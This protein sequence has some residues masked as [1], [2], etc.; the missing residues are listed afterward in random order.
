MLTKDVLKANAALSGLTD[1]QIQAI[2]QL[3]KNDEEVQIGQVTKRIHTQYD[4][5][6]K[7]V[8]G[9]SKP[10][11]V[12]SYDHL[13][14]QLNILKTK[15]DSAGNISQIQSENDQLKADKAKLEQQLQNGSSDQALKTKIQTLEQTVSDRDSEINQLKESHQNDLK[16]M[17]DKYNQ[18]ISKNTSL[19][20]GSLID[21]YSRD[22]KIQYLTT[23]PEGLRKRTFKTEK[24]LF[25]SELKTDYIDDDQG[26]QRL[27][28]RGADGEILRN[29]ENG[30]NPYTAGEL[31]FARDGIKEM[32]DHGKVQNG[33]NTKAG[34]TSQ[35]P[36]NLD[37]SSAKTQVEADK[38]ITQH[39]MTVEG[40]SKSDSKFYDRQTEIRNEAKV[41]DL[42]IREGEASS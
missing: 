2:E 11:N 19:E 8:L 23:I 13:K 22:N 33:A 5:D 42:P 32:I 30:L 20:I 7:S 26:G 35:I 34:N 25:I 4:D 14:Q 41:G 29:K 31:F 3:S 38:M 16:S 39:L 1:E 37:L 28:F 21:Q 40:L 27:V 9:I 12:K 36:A 24:D 18:Q 10:D 6:I 17:T 15:A